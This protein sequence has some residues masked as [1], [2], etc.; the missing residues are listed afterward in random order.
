MQNPPTVYVAASFANAEQRWSASTIADGICD[1]GGISLYPLRDLGQKREATSTA[2]A[3]L[4]GLDCCDAMVLLADVARTGP[5]FEAGWATCRGLPIVVMNSDSDPDRYTMLR[6][7]GAESVSDLSTAA[8]RSVWAAA[9]HRQAAQ[10]VVRLML[11]SGGMDSAAVA[12]IERPEYAL[13][14]DYGQAPAKAERTAARAVADHLGLD[15]AELSVDFS[16]LGSGLITDSPQIP[17]APSPEWFPF[18]NQFLVTV[19][20]AHA[21]KN[22][23]NAVL[24]GIVSGDGDRHADGTS[25]FIL[26]LDSL[27]RSQE[28]EIRLL[29]PQA[30]TAPSDLLVQSGLPEEVVRL[31]HSCHVSNDPC[32]ACPGCD[33]RDEILSLTFPPQS[34]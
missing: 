4:E 15:L 3:D 22:S 21:V 23:Q 31:T 25:E 6:G 17:N 34:N 5:F 1:I 2:R 27:L 12:A 26:N 32:R 20:A 11:L 18:R 19:A 10:N 8:Y 28:M 7:T 29:A 30:K 24:L 33:R 9:E 14:I 16:A 13:F